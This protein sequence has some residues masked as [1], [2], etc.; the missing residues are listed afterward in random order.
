MNRDSK[1]KTAYEQQEET[2]QR[3]GSGV[4]QGRSLL[5]LSDL[6]GMSYWY[7][8][9]GANRAHGWERWQ[10]IELLVIECH[11]CPRHLFMHSI[12]ICIATWGR[13]FLFLQVTMQTQND[14][15]SY[16]RLHSWRAVYVEH[17]HLCLVVLYL[18]TFFLPKG[19]CRGPTHPQTESVSWGG[20]CLALCLKL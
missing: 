2:P 13:H 15:F 19:K 17:K 14:K 16:L 6:E 4:S 12:L 18:F 20:S 9:L 8:S 10:G 11:F 5:N 7:Q 3:G 1:Q